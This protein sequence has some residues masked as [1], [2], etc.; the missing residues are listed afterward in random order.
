[1]ASTLTLAQVVRYAAEYVIEHFA[2]RTEAAQ[3]S[4]AAQMVEAYFLEA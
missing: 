4:I 2:D 1:M 3:A